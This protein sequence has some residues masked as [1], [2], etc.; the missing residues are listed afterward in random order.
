MEDNKHIVAR[1]VDELWNQR[2]LEVADAIFDEDCHTHQL[3]S[4]PPAVA[5]PRGP[6]AIK[7]HVAD[8]LSGFP[9][10]KFTVEQMFADGDR[11]I[12]QLAL[13]GTQTGPWMGIPP[14]RKR[15]NIRVITIHRIRTGKIVEDWVLVESLGLLQ[16]FGA[17]PP[18]GDILTAFAQHQKAPP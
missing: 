3:Q 8:W 10:L 2:K 15:V 12:S 1:F 9:D 5:A 18:T 13:E 11:V 4:G 17:L 6:A 16:Q 14:T 7:A